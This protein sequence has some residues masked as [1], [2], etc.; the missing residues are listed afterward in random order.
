[1]LFAIAVLGTTA[2]FCHAARIIPAPLL[3]Q[4]VDGYAVVAAEVVAS[5]PMAD[6]EYDKDDE[7]VPR[8]VIF[9]VVRVVAGPARLN[10]ILF[11]DAQ[12]SVKLDWGYGAL[13]E[14]YGGMDPTLHMPAAAK[15]GAK[16]Y[17]TIKPK[18]RLEYE[19][20]HG[21]G[22]AEWVQ[23]FDP[24]YEQLI[25]DVPQLAAMPKQQRYRRCLEIVS[26]PSAPDKLRQ[27]ALCGVYYWGAS[28][29]TPEAERLART[30]AFEDLLKVW[31]DPRA[32]FSDEMLFSLDYILS[33]VGYQKPE[34]PEARERVWLE[35]FVSPLPSDSDARIRAL[36]NRWRGTGI[37]ARIL[38][39]RPNETAKRLESIVSNENAQSQ[40]RTAA[41]ITLVRGFQT[42]E[43]ERREWVD[44]FNEVF[45]RIVDTADPSSLRQIAWLVREAGEP[46]DNS[47][48]RRF[49]PTDAGICA[50]KG[51]AARMRQHPELSQADIAAEELNVAI[52]TLKVPSA[53]REDNVERGQ[54]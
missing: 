13:V 27:H 25:R 28:Y 45:P 16:F 42:A 48:R 26:D 24:E 19:H 4:L 18:A 36:G 17:L 22:A 11:P 50:M 47:V 1:M 6:E 33:D 14:E 2:T 21:S 44:F 41:F 37:L 46:T 38:E 5:R 9:K 51:A 35:W 3:V 8:M 7:F 53:S 49:V 34:W 23:Q 39:S 31:N 12:F 20:A 52:K 32:Q 15:P 40:L 30:R 43:Q 10:R 29:G 54:R